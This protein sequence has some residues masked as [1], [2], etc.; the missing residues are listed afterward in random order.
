MGD[1]ATQPNVGT[2][3]P[4]TRIPDGTKVKH[5]VEG[6]EGTIDGLTAIVGHGANLNPDRR[7]QYRIKVQTPRRNLAAEEDLLI[8]LDV[9][10][11]IMMEKAKPE[12]RRYHTDQL[13][14]VFAE[15][16]FVR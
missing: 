2:R 13:R 10:G 11:L 8:L 14:S 4:W 6:Y 15:D 16:R 7:T 5:R 9:E 12:Y 3:K 1:A